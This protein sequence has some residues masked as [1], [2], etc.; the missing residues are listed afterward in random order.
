[1][2]FLLTYGIDY[3]DARGEAVFACWLVV[4][5]LALCAVGALERFV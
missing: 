3:T 1:M 5:A 2:K 4:I